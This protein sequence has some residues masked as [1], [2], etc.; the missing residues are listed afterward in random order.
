MNASTLWRTTSVTAPAAGGRVPSFAQSA[1][2]AVSPAARSSRIFPAAVKFSTP[3]SAILVIVSF[4]PK[5]AWL[6]RSRTIPMTTA[7]CCAVRSNRIFWAAAKLSIPCRAQPASWLT[8]DK[9]FDDS[10]VLA[11]MLDSPFRA[12]YTAVQYQS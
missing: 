9:A 8:G 1:T 7:F 3:L 5:R 11:T 12:V 4:G 6:R 10:F 2:K